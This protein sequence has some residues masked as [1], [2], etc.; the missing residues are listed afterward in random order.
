MGNNRARKEKKQKSQGNHR[1]CTEKLPEKVQRAGDG[2]V[3]VCACLQSRC[4]L[5]LGVCVRSRFF[6]LGI[7]VTGMRSGRRHLSLARLKTCSNNGDVIDGD[8]P[9]AVDERR[10]TSFTHFA[11]FSPPFTVSAESF[12]ALTR[13]E[14][15]RISFLLF[16]LLSCFLEGCSVVSEISTLDISFLLF[17]CLS[18]TSPCYV[19]TRSLASPERAR[20]CECWPVR[21]VAF[22]ALN[23]EKKRKKKI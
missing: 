20:V 13:P 6:R 17:F 5:E 1:Q 7:C 9:R 8:G 12:V 19:N 14:H 22:E 4:E 23:E 16:L 15:P 11:C 21:F 10:E 2:A 3:E 18:T